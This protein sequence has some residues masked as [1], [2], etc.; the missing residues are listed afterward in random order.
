MAYIP[1]SHLRYNL[2][3]HCAAYG[4]EVFACSSTC[5]LEEFLRDIHPVEAALALKV[6][7]AMRIR[8]NAVQP[9]RHVFGLARCGGGH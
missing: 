4:G 8:S 3:P 7:T 9:S 5:E 1:E 2:L 6:M